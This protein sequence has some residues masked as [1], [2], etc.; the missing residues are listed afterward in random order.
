MPEAPPVMMAVLPSN[1]FKIHASFHTFLFLDVI[2]CIE[3]F[4]VRA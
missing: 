1:G 3:R 4:A 2:P